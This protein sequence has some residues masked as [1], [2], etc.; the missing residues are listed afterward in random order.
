M[1]M[2]QKAVARDPKFARAFSSVGM[3]HYLSVD[4]WLH[5]SRGALGQRAGS[6]AGPRPR[7]RTCGSSSTARASQLAPRELAHG[8]GL[9]PRGISL[10]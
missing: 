1:E 6:S 2:F 8:G 9:L 10:G 7:P 4:P 5:E 3:V